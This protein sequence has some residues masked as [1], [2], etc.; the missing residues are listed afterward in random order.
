MQKK[1]NDSVIVCSSKQ[2][3]NLDKLHVNLVPSDSYTDH[4]V[5]AEKRTIRCNTVEDTIL[6]V[7]RSVR[8]AL[9]ELC[10]RVRVHSTARNES[11]LSRHLEHS[12]ELNGQSVVLRLLSDTE[13]SRVDNTVV[14]H[15]TSALLISVILDNH[16]VAHSALAYIIAELSS[17][18]LLNH[19]GRRGDRD[20]ARVGHRA[21]YE[22]QA[23][24]RLVFVEH[25]EGRLGENS[26][27]DSLGVE[28]GSS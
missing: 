8:A 5:L 18:V 24:D 19:V 12:G 4:I 10:L 1:T 7:C 16:E 23:S 9:N 20:V 22:T 26:D 6:T 21:Q 14:Q 11:L 25:A 3:G 13:R 17:S 27:V 2:A 15:G 28:D